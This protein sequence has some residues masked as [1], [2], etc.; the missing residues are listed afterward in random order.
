MDYTAHNKMIL[1]QLKRFEYRP[2]M[3]YSSCTK[4]LPSQ[5]ECTGQPTERNHWT[6]PMSHQPSAISRQLAR[7]FLFFTLLILAI[8]QSTQ[9]YY[10]IQS[11]EPLTMHG[12][13]EE[14]PPSDKLGFGWD[15]TA[16]R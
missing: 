14:A 13:R 6:Q 10:L 3:G 2:S 9:A 16:K 5:P 4:E 12:E 8:A 11:P 7:K 1:E 15:H